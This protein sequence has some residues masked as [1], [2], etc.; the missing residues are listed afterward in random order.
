MKRSRAGLT[1]RP[2]LWPRQDK[3]PRSRELA[4][5]ADSLNPARLIAVFPHAGT[6][7]SQA[8][9][10]AI[11]EGARPHRRRQ[12]PRAGDDRTTRAGRRFGC[13]RNASIGTLRTLQP[14]AAGACSALRSAKSTSPF[15]RSAEMPSMRAEGTV[16]PEVTIIGS[17]V[18]LKW[19][20]KACSAEWPITRTDRSF[21]GSFAAGDR[22]AHRSAGWG[23]VPVAPTEPVRTGARWVRV[24]DRPPS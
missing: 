4:T 2:L 13:S 20:C 21:V 1:H 10:S 6:G 22:T 7:S 24:G 15:Q 11:G 18:A 9:V 3:R 12:C 17:S 16:H 8:F 19:C 23:P 5:K 14:S